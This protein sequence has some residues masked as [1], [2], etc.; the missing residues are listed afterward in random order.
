MESDD[1]PEDHSIAKKQGRAE[2]DQDEATME[3]RKSPY[4]DVHG[5]NADLD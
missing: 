1:K 4:G 3:E 5:E 2:E